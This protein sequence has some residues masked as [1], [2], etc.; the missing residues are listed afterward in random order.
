MKRKQKQKGLIRKF[1]S[2][3]P[4][5]VFP[6]VLFDNITGRIDFDGDMIR[7]HSQRL[8]L[9]KKNG[10]KCIECGI[11]GVYFVK[12]RYSQDNVY[13][14]NL[15]ALN[16]DDEKVL[17]TK[18]HIIPKSKGGKNI[19]SNYQVMCTICNVKKGAILK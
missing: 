16:E 6:L 3:T 1:Y 19:L 5:E 13:H 2:Y 9:F 17:M 4:E 10:C 11:E 8:Q 7:M 12:E 15:Y 14:L 18:D